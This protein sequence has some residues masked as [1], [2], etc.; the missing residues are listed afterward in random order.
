MPEIDLTTDYFTLFKLPLVYRLKRSELDCRY[1]SLQRQVHPDR[2]AAADEREQLHAVQA[3]S[4][5]NNAYQTLRNPLRR[6]I[7]MLQLAGI[8]PVDHAAGVSPEFLAEQIE[9]REQLAEAH[10]ASHP[11]TEFSKLKAH[12]EACSNRLYDELNVLFENNDFNE[13]VGAVQK[14][15]FY[16]KLQHDADERLLLL[17]TEGLQ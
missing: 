13:A 14:L 9:L 7:Y 16:Q 11:A 15:Q 4:Q 10:Q 1:Q 2:Y 3:A 8:D 6:A 12:A 17:E 5:V